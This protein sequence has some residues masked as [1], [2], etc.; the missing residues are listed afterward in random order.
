[1][2][3]KDFLQPT[4]TIESYFE[5][6]NTFWYCT[7][8]RLIKYKQ[9]NRSTAEQITATPLQNISTIQYSE[10]PRNKQYLLYSALYLLLIGITYITGIH[11][12]TITEQALPIPLPISIGILTWI[13]VTILLIPTAIYTVKWAL[14]SSTTL[15]MYC[16]TTDPTLTHIHLE[17]STTYQPDER[18]PLHEFMLVL[19][20]NSTSNQQD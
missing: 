20:R 12:Q 14:S 4:E 1:M 16:D 7:T 18:S 2:S 5:L 6:D 11:L 8:D 13:T 3:I 15:D 9:D 17:D 19:Q 10:S